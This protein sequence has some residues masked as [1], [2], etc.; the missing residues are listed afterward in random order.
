VDVVT[1]VLVELLAIQIAGPDLELHRGTPDGLLPNGSCVLMM[2]VGR[3]H[4]TGRRQGNGGGSLIDIVGA[5]TADARITITMGGDSSKMSRLKSLRGSI[6]CPVDAPQGEE[7]NLRGLVIPETD[8]VYLTLRRIS[9]C[10]DHQQTRHRWTS[11]H[12]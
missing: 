5:R 10:P 8:A 2:I 3:I 4:P 12:L 7:F 9:R 6:R 1:A 11:L